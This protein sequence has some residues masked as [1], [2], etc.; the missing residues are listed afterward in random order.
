MIVYMIA[1]V[2]TPPPMIPASPPKYIPIPSPVSDRP[3]AEV[4]AV[5]VTVRAD[6]QTLFEGPLRVSRTTPASMQREQSEAPPGAC[7]DQEYGGR[8]NNRLR[9]QLTS[10][11][12]QSSQTRITVSVSWTRPV[13]RPCPTPTGSRTVEVTQTVVLPPGQIVTVAGDAGLVVTLRRR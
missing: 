12:S 7:P 9:L 8:A 3:P 1:Q 10:S 5:D 13:E 4:F 11:F 6:K 2:L